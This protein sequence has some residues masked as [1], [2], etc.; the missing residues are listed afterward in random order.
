MP[1]QVFLVY[2]LLLCLL[3]NGRNRKV[4]KHD[5]FSSVDCWSTEKAVMCMW[6]GESGHQFEHL[7]N[8]TDFSE[9]PLYTTW[10]YNKGYW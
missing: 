1:M 6:K 9:P 10:S 4:A 7:I 2:S 5:E 8:S 3:L